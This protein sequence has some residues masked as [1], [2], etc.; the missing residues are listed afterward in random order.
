MTRS[1]DTFFSGI[2]WARLGVPR[3]SDQQRRVAFSIFAR[4]FSFV[5]PRSTAARRFARVRVSLYN[6]PSRSLSTLND[7]TLSGG[8]VQDSKGLLA[9]PRLN[10]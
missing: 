6:E 7:Q 10:R 2:S 8:A 3:S 5:S 9:I 4:R 1:S